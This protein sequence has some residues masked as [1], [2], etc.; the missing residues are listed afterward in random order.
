MAADGADGAAA[1]KAVGAAD[2]DAAE[3]A[4]DDATVIVVGVAV[5]D[6]A[7]E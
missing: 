4:A 5:F 6:E 2:A 7:T 1:D 3:G